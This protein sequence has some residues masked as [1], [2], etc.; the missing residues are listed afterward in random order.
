LEQSKDKLLGAYLDKKKQKEL[1]ETS[2]KQR[3]ENF[4]ISEQVLKKNEKTKNENFEFI[5]KERKE[6]EKLQLELDQKFDEGDD[7]L[8]ELDEKQKKIYD[9]EKKNKNLEKQIEISH[10]KNLEIVKKSLETSVLKKSLE[11]QCIERE[12]EIKEI[13]RERKKLKSK[14]EEEQKKF[15]SM[16][17]KEEK[18]KKIIKESVNIEN[19][20]KDTVYNLE[21]EYDELLNLINEDEKELRELVR[22]CDILQD[23]T[24][25]ANKNKKDQLEEIFKLQKEFNLLENLYQSYQKQI[26]TNNQQIEELEAEKRAKSKECTELTSKCVTLE[27]ELEI[28]EEEISEHQKNNSELKTRMR[29]QQILYESVKSDRLVY[30]KQLKDTNEEVMELKRRYKVM[31]QQISHMKEEIDFKEQR[32]TKEYFKSKELEKNCEALLKIQELLKTDFEKKDSNLKELVERIEELKSTIRILGL[33]KTKITDQL[34][35]ILSERDILSIQVIKRDEELKTLYE[36][37]KIQKSILVKSKEQYKRRLE[38]LH[39]LKGTCQALVGDIAKI[40]D[41]VKKVPELFRDVNALEKEFYTEKLKTKVLLEELQ[42]PINVHKWRKL[43]STDGKLFEMINKI[44]ALQKRLIVKNKDI[45]DKEE[46]LKQQEKVMHELKVYMSRQPSEFEVEMIEKMRDILKEKKQQVQM[47][48]TQISDFRQNFHQIQ[49][50]A[51]VKEKGL[52]IL[53]NKIA[54]VKRQAIYNVDKDSFKKKNKTGNRTEEGNSRP[55]FLIKS[56]PKHVSGGFKMVNP[57]RKKESSNKENAVTF[58]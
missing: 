40:K 24:N 39:D 6:T 1:L 9:L 47:I 43:E 17:K 44:H 53:K 18:Q 13:L 29:H 54:H 30:S 33:Q 26:E 14:I 19:E 34:G 16:E 51:Q 15:T 4:E 5:E 12:K 45:A 11:E 32:L 7:G 10:Q 41:N 38:E 27:E 25:K 55:K 52:K 58:R 48:N 56:L 57:K 21:K 42:C 36:K 49:L 3:K 20:L 31:I 2:I 37:L 8:L 46:I 22:D 28:K 35:L 23:G 50:E